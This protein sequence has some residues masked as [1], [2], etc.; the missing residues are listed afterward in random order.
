M[1]LETPYFDKVNSTDEGFKLF[2]NALNGDSSR[3]IIAVEGILET[4]NSDT[5]VNIIMNTLAQTSGLKKVIFDLKK[6]V[7]VS[8]TGLGSFT[9]ILSKTKQLNIEIYFINVNDKI[10]SV[11]DV[12]GF[13]RF[14]N[15]IGSLADVSA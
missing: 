9:A 6:L 8:S 12:L 15:I 4:D 1:A 13:S 14:F 11:I 7:Y 3:L 2:G 10:Q 5:F